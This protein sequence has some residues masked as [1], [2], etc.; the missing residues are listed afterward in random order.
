MV[1][2]KKL[3]IVLC[4]TML[5]S[6]TVVLPVCAQTPTPPAP[7]DVLIQAITEQ[8]QR[9]EK[10]GTKETTEG[11]NLL[12]GEQAKQVGMSLPEV[13]KIY[14][15]AYSAAAAG[16]PWYAEL[17]KDWLPNLG[18]VAAVLA[19]FAAIFR[20]KIED[21]GEKLVNSIGEAL[22][23]R[24]AG[25]KPFWRLA[26]R[27][28][29][30]ALY[31]KHHELKLPF[32]PGRPLEM[33]DVYVPVKVSGKGVDT[34]TDAYQA[35]EKHKKLVVL[36]APG[37]G[38]SILLRHVAL[39]YAE[40]ELDELLVPVLVEL[41]RLNDAGT[42]MFEQ[43]AALLKQNDFP[44]SE[45]FLKAWL[46]TGQL[47]LMFDG[48]DEV[49]TDRREQVSAGIRDLL[50]EY[51]GCHAVVT[52]RTQVYKGEFADW[53]DQTLEVAEFSDQQVQ[54]FLFAWR[55]ELPQ[56]KSVEH[57]WANLSERP[58]I[59][60]LARNPLMLTIIAF[61]YADTEFVLPHSRAEFYDTTVTV[62]LEQWKEKRNRYKAASKRLVMQR[63]ALFMQDTATAFGYR[64]IE[65]PVL[66]TEIKK[67]LPALNLT[68]NDA[69]A[70]LNEIVERSGLMFA[71]DGGLRY[72]FSQLS[73]QEFFA[74]NALMGDADGLINRFNMSPDVWL[75]T[76]I[77]WCGLEHDSTSFIRS[78]Y[79]IAPITALACLTEAQKVDSSLADQIL[80][81]YVL[82]LGKNAPDQALIIQQLSMIALDPRSR[83]RKLLN[84]LVRLT[85]T[86][87]KP[88][89]Y[90]VAKILSLTRSEVGIRAISNHLADEKIRSLIVNIGDVAVPVLYEMALQ[91]SSDALYALAA[92][93]TASAKS[94]L[95][96]LGYSYEQIITSIKVV[97]A[98]DISISERSSFVMQREAKIS[99]KLK[100][101][102][103]LP[104]PAFN[105]KL[106][107][108]SK[109]LCKSGNII[110]VKH[111]DV[112]EDIL[113]EFVIQSE[114][115]DTILLQLKI[116]DEVYKKRSLEIFFFIDHPYVWGVPIQDSKSFFGRQ[117]EISRI[118]RNCLSP[119][120]AHTLIVGEQRSGKTS[121]INQAVARISIPGIPIYVSLSSIDRNSATRA[122]EWLVNQIVEKLLKQN[123]LETGFTLPPLKYPSD[124]TH[125][126][127]ETIQGIRA[128]K[129]ELA[130][131]V[132]LMDEGHLLGEV[133]I[134]FQE[135]LRQ[136]FND[137]VTGMRVV[138]ACYYNFQR[139]VRESGSPLLNTFE[140]INLKPLDGNDLRNLI[141]MPA[142]SFNREF[143][144]DAIGAIISI[145][146]GH[147]YFCQCLCAKS[148][149]IEG[150]SSIISIQSVRHAE[151]RLLDEE[152]EIFWA[153]YWSRLSPEEKSF[154]GK[155]VSGQFEQLTKTKTVFT[156]LNEKSIV[157]ES[158]GK[159]YFTCE[160]FEIWS[161]QLYAEEFNS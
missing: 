111:L 105:V 149:V 6:I 65:L 145:S 136:A 64:T 54:R 119:N 93:D 40:R 137:L 10:Q 7:R 75:E 85:A 128:K 110:E 94:M 153:G 30:A 143:S 90:D 43:L 139:N 159:Y 140:T 78:V 19:L 38:K 156:S 60:A 52:C 104:L 15:D 98:L 3:G 146:G 9:D 87:N 31:E 161:K 18:W 134:T 114:A 12:F 35:I 69:P 21:A 44:N 61:L 56:G 83:G 37:A 49:N 73:L 16:R 58:R 42:K 59:L 34:L 142:K 107:E 36:G 141:T 71:L 82:S 103:L 20:K 151:Q 45:N 101:T 46:K 97:D 148:F 152:K 68:D 67:I 66:L 158:N 116:N 131:L 51:P 2:A 115:A 77:L 22:Y 124:I 79:E 91:K 63:L 132:L 125:S 126:L 150:N 76:A 41:N 23:N 48:L 112:G 106:E 32:R 135:A 130:Y 84:D 147:P 24:F 92:I 102:T 155:L 55:K 122:S 62:L 144:S 33:K 118:V 127:R 4:L 96:K 17:T 28:Y 100:N 120:G 123:A 117:S 86:E 26:L 113:V 133:D 95:L 5:L 99:L 8:A 129:G 108:T 154:L 53:A 160:L 89:L 88:L 57:L 29:K 39:T 81:S 70:L 157:R 121:L 50:A 47:L 14:E 1:S 13:K 11:L 27:R 72:K 74:A 109:Y 25:Y 138:F 80:G